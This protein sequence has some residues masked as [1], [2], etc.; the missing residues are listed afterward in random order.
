MNTTQSTDQLAALGRIVSH[1]K[2]YREDPGNH[3]QRTYGPQLN[4][5]L[6]QRLS[7]QDLALW[8]SLQIDWERSK[9]FD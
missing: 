4:Q 3:P 5:Y 7:S 2:A 8:Q 6:Q 1:V 9:N